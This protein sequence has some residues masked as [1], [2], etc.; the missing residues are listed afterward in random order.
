MLIVLGILAY[1]VIG[2]AIVF[3]VEYYDGPSGD[4]VIW[5]C[6]L[7]P[8]LGPIML[9]FAV[10]EFAASKRHKRNK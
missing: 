10:Q 7:W 4:N 3:A 6:I 5:A 1:F 9:I 8:I 2:L